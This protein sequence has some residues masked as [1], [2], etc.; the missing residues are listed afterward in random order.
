M[1]PSLLDAS[2]QYVLAYMK[3]MGKLAND[4][5]ILYQVL[6][7]SILC[8]YIYIYIYICIYIQE[9]TSTAV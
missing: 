1:F 5:M 4:P 9:R 3:L 8:F 2:G 7:R 6:S